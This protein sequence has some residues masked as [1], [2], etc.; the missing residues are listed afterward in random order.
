MSQ[1][2]VVVQNNQLNL[3]NE[4]EV[5]NIQT[6]LVILYETPLTTNEYQCLYSVLDSKTIC[7]VDS[8]MK[9][10]L[11]KDL[12]S[13]YNCLLIDVRDSELK[14]WALDQSS[15]LY[16]NDNIHSI[17]KK[18]KGKH[19]EEGDFVLLKKSFGVNVVRKYLPVSSKTFNDYLM[20]IKS[21]HVQRNIVNLNIL[22]K[23]YYLAVSCFGR[24]F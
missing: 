5:N 18:K 20:R 12:L 4:S 3:R 10:S 11:Y 14:Q 7:E 15:Y 8:K 23:V 1:Q 21:D 17:Y 16:S 13:S 2:V 24:K 19:I 22:E 6:K 9:S